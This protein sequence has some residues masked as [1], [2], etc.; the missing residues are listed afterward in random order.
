M[1]TNNA[2]LRAELTDTLNRFVMIKVI[3]AG[4]LGSAAAS[5]PDGMRDRY[6]YCVVS[7]GIGTCDTG[8]DLCVAEISE[9][10]AVQTA[11]NC[12]ESTIT[13][14]SVRYD[15]LRSVIQGAVDPDERL[16]FDFMFQISG[17]YS[18][19]LNYPRRYDQAG[20]LR[21]SSRV[22]TYL[23]NC[24]DAVRALVDLY[25]TIPGVNWRIPSHTL[26][27]EPKP[28][29]T[30]EAPQDGED[31]EYRFKLKIVRGSLIQKMPE[32]VVDHVV[33]SLIRNFE[34]EKLSKVKAYA[35]ASHLMRLTDADHEEFGQ[36]IREAVSAIDVFRRVH[37]GQNDGQVRSW[38]VWLY[39]IMTENAVAIIPPL[40]RRE[41]T[42]HIRFLNRQCVTEPLSANPH[43]F[44]S[45]LTEAM[46]DI[47]WDGEVT[48]DDFMTMI[49]VLK[50]SE[51][52]AARLAITLRV[53]SRMVSSRPQLK[54]IPFAV[55]PVEY[56]DMVVQF[57]PRKE[58]FAD[59]TRNILSVLA[60]D[61]LRDNQDALVT[62]V[63]IARS[64][65]LEA[66]EVGAI[67][68]RDTYVGREFRMILSNPFDVFMLVRNMPLYASV[69][70]GKAL[71][72]FTGPMKMLNGFSQHTIIMQIATANQS[73]DDDLDIRRLSPTFGGCML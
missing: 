48:R 21:N 33:A 58:H 29:E 15:R 14:T 45:L 31:G 71:N 39:S 9:G 12:S 42:D 56:R 35:L 65:N 3:L 1:Y 32:A 53:L 43:F 5:L 38:L 37:P 40:S 62:L 51:K 7:A 10:M 61:P 64:L 52:S 63:R 57:H 68:Q 19:F 73:L 70:T 26:S 28:A 49:E 30:V 69:W 60:L 8:T 44:T 11:F 66:I 46:P 24:T 18:D 23:S 34:K 27:A 50:R 6:C 59:V 41:I 13:E 17:N 2:S 47:E 55:V 36:A 20:S 25:L 54:H 72:L 4:N 22:G 16:R 67:T